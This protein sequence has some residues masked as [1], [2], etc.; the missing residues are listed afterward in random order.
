MDE[1]QCAGI[2]ADGSGAQVGRQGHARA[3]A[4]LAGRPLQVP[5]VGRDAIRGFLGAPH[6]QLAQVQ[7]AQQRRA[8]VLQPLDYGGVFG[9]DEV[10]VNAG[11]VTG[12]DAVG[13]ELVFDGHRNAGQWP[14]ILSP[15]QL[16]LHQPG[17]VQGFLAG[18]RDVGGEAGVQPV[19]SFQVC[20]HRP[21]G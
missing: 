11:A 15:L 20:R 6:G 21:G 2:L 3:T 13:P 1:Q 14:G 12:Q 16:V 9:G 10:A 7:L 5:G 19:Y 4:G 18:H 17:G 8:R